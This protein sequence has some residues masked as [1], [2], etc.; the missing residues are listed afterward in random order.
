[1]KL[2][3][4]SYVLFEL[5]NNGVIRSS[6]K[7]DDRDFLQLS[8]AA[9]GS[10]TRKFYYDERSNDAVW[11]FV[12][13]NT[14]EAEYTVTEDK[15]GRII[16]DFDFEK[17]RITRLPEGNGILRITPIPK[18]GKIDY[19]KNYTKGIAGSEWMYCT[20]KFLEDTGELI[21]MFTAGQIRLFSLFV[22]E[23]VEML[24]VVDN[25]DSEIPDDI[26]WEIFNYVLVISL[27]VVNQ[28]IDSTDDSNPMVQAIK[29]KLG[30]PQPV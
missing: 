11:Q 17:D 21:Y 24:A 27:K 5:Y 25:D 4:I 28:P 9:K 12:A 19:S 26:V 30:T 6:H 29:S 2:K 8:R 7:L 15:R 18:E 1:M 13:A 22:P 3:V 14:S 16:V 20:K 23:M 10:V